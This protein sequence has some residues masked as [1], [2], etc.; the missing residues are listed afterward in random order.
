[1]PELVL[2]VVVVAQFPVPGFGRRHASGRHNSILIGSSLLD[3][4]Q[5]VLCEAV[6]RP[7]SFLFMFRPSFL[8]L[9]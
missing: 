2:A 3:I 5:L 9:S 8:S 6:C 7:R 1:M 4:S